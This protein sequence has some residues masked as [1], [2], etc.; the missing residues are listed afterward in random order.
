MPDETVKLIKLTQSPRDANRFYAEFNNGDAFSVTVAHIA[1][2]GLYTNAEIP[3]PKYKELSVAAEKSRARARVMRMLGARPMSKGE[4]REKLIEKGERDEVASD[5]AEYMEAIGTVN[6]TEYAAM[7]VSHYA[8]KGYG[9]GKIRNEL[10]RRKVP[11]DLWEEALST[12]PETEDTVFTLI[13]KKLSGKNADRKEIK[14]VSDMLLRRGFSYE[15]IKNGLRKF[16]D[17]L[18]D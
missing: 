12:M 13:E 4:I 2:F 11:K 15:E 3:L 8:K 6:E 17:G 9:V 14:K 18:E 7:I 16:T 10:Y 5:A 1:D